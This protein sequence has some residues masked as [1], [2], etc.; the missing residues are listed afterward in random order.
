MR[1]ALVLATLAIASAG[2]ATETELQGE[3]DRTLYAV[4]VV[5]SESFRTLDLTPAELEMVRRGL[6]DALEGR[7]VLV[8][9]S[10]FRARVDALGLER[11]AAMERRLVERYTAEPKASRS[12]SGLV[13]VPLAEGTGPG[14]TAEDVVKVQY[15]G[16]LADG[17]VFDDTARRGTPSAVPLGQT[18]PCWKEA[19]PMMKIGGK[20]KVACPPALAYGERGMPRLI[21]PN[22]MLFFEIELVSIPARVITTEAPIPGTLPDAP[23]DGARGA[24]AVTGPVPN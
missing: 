19:L 14:P 7:E 4:G 6:R 8:D 20:A 24:P 13:F 16:R 21:P 17:T 3:L 1:T 23:F 9:P 18:I 15:S 22:A 2:A 5:A 10:A 12:A 11:R